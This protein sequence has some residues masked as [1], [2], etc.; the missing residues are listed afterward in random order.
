[1][2]NLAGKVS[3]EEMS[4]EALMV[5]DMLSQE[6]KEEKL[7]LEAQLALEL[8]LE[9][10]LELELELEEELELELDLPLELEQMVFA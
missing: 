4:K 6:L 10:A 7:E 3:P 9:L 5:R 2:A 1:M 8:E